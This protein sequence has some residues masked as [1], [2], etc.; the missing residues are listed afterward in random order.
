MRLLKIILVFAI[1]S[2]FASSSIKVFA[3]GG[4]LLLSAEPGNLIHDASYLPRPDWWPDEL[5]WDGSG[6]NSDA[7]YRY[8]ASMIRYADDNLHFWSCSEGDGDINIADY[9]RYRHSSDGGLTWT[10]DEIVLAPSVGT[11]DGWA[12]CDPNV[13]RFGGYY[14][15]AY[16]A[17]N[18]SLS[19]GLNNH[20]FLARSTQP[21]GPYSKWDGNG[22]G[23]APKAIIE[24]TGI[25]D[26]WGYGEPNM[27]VVE[28]IM[29]L[30]FTDGESVPRTR[31][32]TTSVNSNSW[33]NT[34]TQQGLAISNRDANE[35]QTDIKY[36]PEVDLFIATAIGE[37]FTTLSYVHVWWSAD[38]FNFQPVSNDV[39][40]VNIQPTAHNLSMSGNELGHAAM[41]RKEYISY[42]YTGPDGD[43]G[44]W[45]AWLNPLEISGAGW[46]PSEEGN[47][48]ILLPIIM[49]LLEED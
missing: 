15:L 12:V 31:V 1:G 43:W 46:V 48:A 11:D 41:G 7:S 24:Y 35:D 45:N 4:S 38:G 18:D 37:R 3:S 9:I 13:V 22:W 27:V 5:D 39:V 30:Y 44:R 34:L 28:D 47:S 16:T 42:S 14:Y 25:A 36:L 17:T 33:P 6:L 19:G 23:G 8:G 20:I 49:L 21:N 29:Y 40:S 26:R 32:A 10:D 2:I